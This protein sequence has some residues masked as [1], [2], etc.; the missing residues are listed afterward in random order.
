[1]SLLF[2]DFF[3]LYKESEV[4]QLEKRITKE[5]VIQNKKKSIRQIN[6]LLEGY[7]N[8]GNDDLLK[9][10][11]LLAYWLSSFSSYI[12]QES[13]FNPK[14]LLAYKRGDIIRVN[15]GFRVGTEFGGLHYAVVLDKE[16]HHNSS[17]ITVIPLSS[18]KANKKTH[19]RDLYLGT[20]LYNLVVAKFNNQY[21]FVESKLNELKS[22]IDALDKIP[23]DKQ[24]PDVNITIQNVNK[25][26]SDLGMAMKILS[27]DHAEIERMKTGSIAKI[28]QITTISKMRI[29]TPKKSTDFLYNVHLSP[30]AM[31]RINAKIKELYIFNE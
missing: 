20:E 2:L 8:S 24:T 22:I 31:S 30:N 26:I 15:F 21:D 23:V 14:K 19:D 29:Y 28:E 4:F 6:N 18:A 11:N 12:E 27:K 13:N 7:I 10:A 3:K 17:T 1:M 16:G 25:Q 9:K 5:N